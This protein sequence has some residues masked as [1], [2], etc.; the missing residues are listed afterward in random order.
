LQ[1][2]SSKKMP[3]RAGEWQVRSKRFIAYT[4]ARHDMALGFWIPPRVIFH[5]E[6]FLFVSYQKDSPQKTAE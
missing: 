6:T 1:T 5:S 4:S 2:C 3:Y